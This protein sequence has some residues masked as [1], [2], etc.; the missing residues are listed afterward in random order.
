LPLIVPTSFGNAFYIFLMR[1]FFLTLPP[2]LED[3]ARIDSANTLRVL[4]H[5]ILP[6]SVSTLATVV[7]FTFQA[8]W[9]DL[10]QP[11]I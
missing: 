6:I 3:A 2:D 4:R 10:L 9:N 1:Q 8:S 5:V 11:L 7:I